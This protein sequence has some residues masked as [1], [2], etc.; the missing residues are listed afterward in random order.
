MG[1]T[2]TPASSRFEGNRFLI[3]REVRREL[4]DPGE[5]EPTVREHVPEHGF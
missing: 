5:M 2:V 3:R 4:G 1:K